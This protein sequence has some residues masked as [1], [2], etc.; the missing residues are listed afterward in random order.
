MLLYCI[1]AALVLGILI[2]YFAYRKIV[3]RPTE[4]MDNIDIHFQMNKKIAAEIK[5]N[6]EEYMKKNQAYDE[7][8][9]REVT[10]ATVLEDLQRNYGAYLYGIAYDQGN[11][12]LSHL[13]IE[14]ICNGMEVHFHELL[15]LQ[16][17]V[18][19]QLHKQA[20]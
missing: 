2:T 12:K 15:Q 17:E 4:E 1:V 9:Y 6:L 3:P 14:A 19:L 10:F 5:N 16:R 11:R 20:I 13:D 8:F 18:N 7:T